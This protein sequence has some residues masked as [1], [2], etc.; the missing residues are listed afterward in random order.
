MEAKFPVPKPV[1]PMATFSLQKV[2]DSLRILLG[3]SQDGCFF[4]VKN[5]RAGSCCKTGGF[6]KI[7][8]DGKL[9]QNFTALPITE[10]EAMVSWKLNIRTAVSGGEWTPLAHSL[11]IR[12]LMPRAVQ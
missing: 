8:V 11:T 2:V 7:Q 6:P 1:T 12:R 10:T 4:P 9:V 3:V 5:Q